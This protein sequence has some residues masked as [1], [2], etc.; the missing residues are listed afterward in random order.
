MDRDATRGSPR[1]NQRDA[2]NWIRYSCRTQNLNL[3]HGKLVPI[4]FGHIKS[5]VAA[6]AFP[7]SNAKPFGNRSC[8]GFL[9]QSGL[10]ALRPDGHEVVA[11]AKTSACG[12]GR[13]QS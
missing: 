6:H 2:G 10:K 11:A 4:Q 8:D 12:D 9:S 13:G 5:T 3:L 7:S 1:A